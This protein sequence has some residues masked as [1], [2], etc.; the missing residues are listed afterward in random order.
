[1]LLLI[2]SLGHATPPKNQG[3]LYKTVGYWF[4]LLYEPVQT[5]L[6]LNH[7]RQLNMTKYQTISVYAYYEIKKL[8]NQIKSNISLVLESCWERHNWHRYIQFRF[9]ELFYCMQRRLE[10]ICNSIC[11]WRISIM[12]SKAS[13]YTEYSYAN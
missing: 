13:T 6:C 1:M 2:R 3:I 5:I 11:Q 9:S 7:I 4:T 8:H 10:F 12:W